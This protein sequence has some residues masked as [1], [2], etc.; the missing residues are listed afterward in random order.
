[1]NV[2]HNSDYIHVSCIFKEVRVK[3]QPV[4]FQDIAV[5]WLPYLKPSLP[6]LDGRKTGRYE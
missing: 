3:V 1:M 6:S 2:V 5:R 4:D